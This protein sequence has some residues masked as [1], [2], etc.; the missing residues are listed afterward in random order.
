MLEFNGD[1]VAR[2]LEFKAKLKGKL[3]ELL[4]S[5][6]LKVASRDWHAQRK[7][8]PCGMTIH[9]GIGCSFGCLY[10]YI[11]DMGFPPKP[12]AYP[13]TGLQLVYSLALNPYFVPGSNGTLLAFGSVTE[14]FLEVSLDRTF[15]YLK[16]LRDYLGNPQQIS[17]KAALDDRSIEVFTSSADPLID[18]LV[19]VTTLKHWKILE[20]G[21]P[22]PL[23]RLE[24]AS[25]LARRGFHVTLFMR[26]IIPG[27]TDREARSILEEALNHGIRDVVPGTLRVTPRILR[28]LESSKL[29]DVTEIGRRLPRKP[30]NPREQIP[31]R[32]S[33]LKKLVSREAERL[34]LRVHPASCASN[35]SAHNQACA[36]C[37]MGPCGNLDKLPVVEEKGVLEVARVLKVNI[38]EARITGYKVVVKCRDRREGCDKLKHYIIALARRTP[39]IKNF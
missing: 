37:P 1:T 9:T 32:G 7:P 25:K 36:A 23:D 4:G 14:P 10:C 18:V 15:E 30:V 26:P 35:I 34:G 22:N 16:Y 38:E 20:P 13:L 24:F 29:I 8:I 3:E 19:T 5:E 17:T 27:V 28:R 11:F 39:Y 2:I 21:A 12:R 33:D 6:E 31:I